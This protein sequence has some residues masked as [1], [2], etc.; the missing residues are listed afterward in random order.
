[1]TLFR[2][3]FPLLLQLPLLFTFSR[4][5]AKI[6]LGQ[7]NF[8]FPEGKHYTTCYY[9]ADFSTKRYHIALPNPFYSLF[10]KGL[11]GTD[12]AAKCEALCSET[13]AEGKSKLSA[14]KIKDTLTTDSIADERATTSAKKDPYAFDDRCVKFDWPLEE[15]QQQRFNPLYT[16]LLCD[17]LLNVFVYALLFVRSRRKATNFK[18]FRIPRAISLPKIKWRDIRDI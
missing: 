10:L 12:I 16:S 6:D 7:G 18:R 13:A 5:F 15:D 17:T 1:M 14:A 8:V 11:T 4:S 2:N 3:W 9:M